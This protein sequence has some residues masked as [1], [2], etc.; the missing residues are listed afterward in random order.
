MQTLK[1]NECTANEFTMSVAIGLRLSA[2]L[3]ARV[4]LA[5]KNMHS[6]QSLNAL[7]FSFCGRFMW[8]QDIVIFFSLARTRALAI[9]LLSHQMDP[10][11]SR[12]TWQA[13]ESA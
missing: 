12:K 13:N 5:T 11:T 7:R 6:L 3:R 1:P 8:S 10:D 2:C 4:C 9:K